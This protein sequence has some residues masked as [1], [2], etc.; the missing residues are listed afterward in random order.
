MLVGMTLLRLL[1][2]IKLNLDVDIP[3][4]TVIVN[5]D[6]AYDLD[7]VILR[8]DII[9]DSI[10]TNPDLVK[11]AKLFKKHLKN[12]IIDRFTGK[13]TPDYNFTSKGQ[14]N[15]ILDIDF[16]KDIITVSGDSQGIYNLNDELYMDNISID[17]N[18]VIVDSIKNNHDPIEKALFKVT[19]PEYYRIL[20][21]EQYT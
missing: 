3:K 4:N 16:D 1:V 18:P 2:K 14:V 15:I 9:S 19:E 10:K 13:D 5:K 12:D 7:E 17:V 11:E 6:T 20:Y 8:G 21:F